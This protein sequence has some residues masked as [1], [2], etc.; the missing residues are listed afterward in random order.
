MRDL[1][2]KDVQATWSAP[3]RMTREDQEQAG[4]L[5]RQVAPANFTAPEPAAPIVRRSVDELQVPELPDWQRL[6]PAPE[7]S[8]TVLKTS[9]TDKAKGYTLVTLPLSLAG[10]GLAVLIVTVGFGVPV[11]SLA[12]LLVAWTVFAGAW[13]A[14]WLAVVFVSGDGAA[15]FTSWRAWRVVEREQSMR[16]A[17]YR[18]KLRRLQEGDR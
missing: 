4:L 2:A 7:S 1:D 14:G 5:V 10:A 3:R 18:E 16:L 12:A 11:F 13:L 17:F 8:V 9:Y 15:L 6:P